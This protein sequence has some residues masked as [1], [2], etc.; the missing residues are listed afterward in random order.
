MDVFVF[1]RVV[2]QQ[3]V[4]EKFN[5]ISDAVEALGLTVKGFVNNS[6]VRTEL[7]DT[8][9]FEGYSGPFWCGVDP[10]GEPVLRYEADDMQ[11]LHSPS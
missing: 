7:H 11:Q 2:D 10:Q 5:S 4:Q 6:T 9:T 8:P 3:I 1:A